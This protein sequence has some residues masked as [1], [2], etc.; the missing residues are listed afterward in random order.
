M[1]V[2]L[3]WYVKI[4]Y[5]VSYV[6]TSQKARGL[7]HLRLHLRFIYVPWNLNYTRR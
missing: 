2:T 4:I 6:T 1:A 3:F 7:L 5:E